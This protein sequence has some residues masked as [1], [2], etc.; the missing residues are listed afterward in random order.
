MIMMKDGTTFRGKTYIDGDRMRSEMTES[1][2][3]TVTI[4]RKDQQKIYIVLASQK[5]VMEM[6]YDPDKFSGKSA[7]SFGPE[8]KFE[9]IGPES[10]DGVPCMKYKVTSE[11][12]N[13]VFYFWLDLAQKVPLRMSAADNSFI[14]KWRHYKVGPQDP[15][16][17]EPPANYQVIPMPSMPGMPDGQGGGGQ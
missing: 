7:A 11:K 6:P 5:M 10:T 13:Q 1:G 3:D 4:V 14:L 16:L 12:N 15:S 17:F 8:G 9:L 2:V